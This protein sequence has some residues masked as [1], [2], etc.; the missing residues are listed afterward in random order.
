[1][2]IKNTI[3]LSEYEIRKIEKNQEDLLQKMV[4]KYLILVREN[5]KNED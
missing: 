3:S 4:E 1:M 5:Y 2:H